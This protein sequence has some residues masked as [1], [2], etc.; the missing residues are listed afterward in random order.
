[1]SFQAYLNESLAVLQ[2]LSSVE[3]ILQEAVVASC[4][5]LREGKSLLVCGNG[6]SA[7]DAQ[8]ITGE[9]VGRYLKERKA[10]KAI[11][12]SDNAA[13]LTALGNDYGYEHVFSRQVEAYGEEG[14]ILVGL[15]TSGRSPNV[16][17]AFEIARDLKMI[18]ISFTGEREGPLS[19]LSTFWI[20]APS[21]H[22][23]LIQQVHLVL[24][25][26]FCQKVEETLSF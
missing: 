11:C 8:H 1:M 5:A 2:K 19:P 14:G 20:P 4:G 22:T 23:P 12:L 6:G 17:K 21:S 9:L 26:F 15:S 18:T 24:Y 13:V 3:S 16:V 7:S 25:H 10:L